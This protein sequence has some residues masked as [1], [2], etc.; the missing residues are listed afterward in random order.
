M[1]VIYSLHDPFCPLNTRFNDSVGDRCAVGHSEQIV[2]S[3]HVHGAQ[4]GGH[5][6]K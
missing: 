2:G 4:D 3:L 6:S 5:D 1:Q